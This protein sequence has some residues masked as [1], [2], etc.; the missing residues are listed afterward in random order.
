M[1]NAFRTFRNCFGTLEQ[2]LRHVHSFTSSF[3][4]HLIGHPATRGPKDSVSK[5]QG[6]KKAKKREE[7]LSFLSKA[8]A[9]LLGAISRSYGERLSYSRHRVFEEDSL[10]FFFFAMLEKAEN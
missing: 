5:M 1:I 2:L 3:V 7:T 10:L 4:Q 6:S 8:K 9:P